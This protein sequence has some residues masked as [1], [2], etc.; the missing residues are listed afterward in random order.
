[1]DANYHGGVEAL[2]TKTPEHN[3]NKNATVP[4]KKPLID[5]YSTKTKYQGTLQTNQVKKNSL[6]KGKGEGGRN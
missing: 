2:K 1:M 5:G 6:R 3:G 4:G